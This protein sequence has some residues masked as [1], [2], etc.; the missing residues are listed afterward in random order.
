MYSISDGLK[1]VI[2]FGFQGTGDKYITRQTLGRT[3]EYVEDLT[4]K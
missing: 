1:S 3:E 2:H 4:I